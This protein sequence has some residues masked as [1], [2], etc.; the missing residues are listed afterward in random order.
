MSQK[1]SPLLLVGFVIW[2]WLMLV[3]YAAIPRRS[4]FN[5]QAYLCW[6]TPWTDSYVRCVKAEK[7]PK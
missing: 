5:G 4:E 2:L 6:N 1:S 7:W 3:S